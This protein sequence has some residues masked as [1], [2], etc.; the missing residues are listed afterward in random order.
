MR[1]S[2]RPVIR[3]TCAKSSFYPG[4]VLGAWHAYGDTGAMRRFISRFLLI[5]LLAV[6]IGFY[7]LLAPTPHRI[8]QAHFELIKA[9]M[10]KADVE[11]I[12]GVQA[13]QYDWAEPEPR[14]YTLMISTIALAQASQ[15]DV[16]Q[17]KHVQMAIRFLLKSSE[18]GVS[19]TWVSRHGA[20]R[21]HFDSNDHV[22]WTREDEVRIVPPWQ[23]WWR[24][25]RDR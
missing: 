8:D 15:V 12:F 22:L 25:F 23:H 7:P 21:V 17:E 5:A 14:R 16:K 19:E 11:A 20:F 3:T 9:G 24:Q 13:G 2:H 10:T 1:R 18:A 6:V 4:S